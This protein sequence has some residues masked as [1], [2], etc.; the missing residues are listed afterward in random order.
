MIAA[1]LPYYITTALLFK[2][3]EAKVPLDAITVM[4]QK[5]V[6]D[7]FTAK[8]S[9]KDYNA[10]SII[11]S[12]Y[13]DCVP[14]MKIPRTIFNPKPNVDSAVIQ[15]RV[16]QN[17]LNI[18]DEQGF[19][20]MVKAC[21]KQ[22]RKTIYNNYREYLKDS[23]LAQEIL[24]KAGIELSARA[25]TCTMEDFIRLKGVQDEKKSIR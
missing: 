10:L 17:P 6:A 14:V 23:D 16:K 11:S 19:F 12:V 22:R 9:T 2:I 18:E 8:V 20:E 24:N 15:F 4:M 7:R 1:N 21:F 25:E 13:Y 5:E 3:F